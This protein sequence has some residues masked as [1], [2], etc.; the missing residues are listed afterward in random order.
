MPLPHRWGRSPRPD[1]EDMGS[2]SV[3]VLPA[4]VCCAW[5]APAVAAQGPPAFKASPSRVVDGGTLRLEAAGRLPRTIRVWLRGRGYSAVVSAR[6]RG[7]GW[8][9]RLPS[10]HPAAATRVEVCVRLARRRRCLARTAIE[11]L[12][13]RA[14]GPGSP[15]FR[16]PVTTPG[17]TVPPGSLGSRLGF[18]EDFE[19]LSGAALDRRLDQIAATG[20]KWA[21]FQLLWNSVQSGGPTKHWWKP[22]D[23]LV[24]GLRA[25]GIQPIA[26]LGT[27]PPW[28]R[29]PGCSVE[30]CA[31]AD[32]AAFA[33]FAAEAAARYAPEG[34]RTWELWN[35]PNVDTFWKPNPDPGRYAALLKTTYVAIKGVDPGATLLTGGLAPTDDRFDTGGGPSRIAPLEFFQRLYDSGAHGYFDAVGWHPYTYPRMPGTSGLD[36]AWWQAYGPA[37]NLRSMMAAHGDSGKQVWAT[38]FGAHTD[39]DG[40]GYVD[41][42]TQARIIRSGISQW[43]AFPWSGPMIL[44]RYQ[45]SGT[46]LSDRDM[47]FGLVRADGT[48]KPALAAFEALA[49]GS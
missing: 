7:R 11:L 47:F 14:S 3:L 35:E 12:P 33:G 34:L 1:A 13:G 30:T 2:R 37:L 15:L 48:P 41:E 42:A 27:T 23:D 26:V 10:A 32:P 49:S 36:D 44:Y 20:A 38:E 5:L 21:R 31:P 17:P 43:S 40:E 18:F 46:D 25:R 24:A 28:A 29:E 39:P 4:L 9:A 22:F 19:Y 45:D 6:R 16:E 8:S